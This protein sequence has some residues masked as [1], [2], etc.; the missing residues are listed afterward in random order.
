MSLKSSR[1]IWLQK[2]WGSRLRQHH[3]KSYSQS[4]GSSRLC[5]E[6]SLELHEEVPGTSR[7]WWQ[8]SC[9]G[10]KL[11]SSKLKSSRKEPESGPE[12]LRFILIRQVQFA[13]VSPAISRGQGQHHADSGGLKHMLHFEN[14]GW[15]RIQAVRTKS[16]VVWVPKEVL[17]LRGQRTMGRNGLMGHGKEGINNQCPGW[18]IYPSLPTIPISFALR[19]S[20]QCLVSEIGQTWVQIPALLL[21]GS[22]I[23]CKLCMLLKP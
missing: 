1:Q 6:F 23:L 8:D 5:V 12:A 15:N 4:L 16:E 22:V 7:A 9:S 17:G 11:M 19:I 14:Q 18:L 20:S 10:P 21:S 2:Q 3:Q 13:F